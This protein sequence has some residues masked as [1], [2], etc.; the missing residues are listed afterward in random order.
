[1][2]DHK[3]LLRRALAPKVVTKLKRFD[4]KGSWIDN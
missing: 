2:V 3:F 4:V 1:M